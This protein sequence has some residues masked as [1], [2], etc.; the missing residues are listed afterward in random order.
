MNING[1]I[2]SYFKHTEFWDKKKKQNTQSICFDKFRNVHFYKNF[3]IV[4]IET[5]SSKG[6]TTTND[7]LNF[8]TINKH[9]GKS[10]QY[11]WR[12]E[13][14]F[15]VRCLPLFKF[16]RSIPFYL[17]DGALRFRG[18]RYYIIQRISSRAFSSS[19]E[20]QLV[21]HRLPAHYNW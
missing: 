2:C 7:F 3:L 1:H 9:I 6:Y 11:Y 10:T 12:S 14:K 16:G 13:R 17:N 8:R 18:L 20:K 4:Y 15:L 19:L 5:S 21:C